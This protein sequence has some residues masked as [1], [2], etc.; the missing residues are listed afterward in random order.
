MQ[1]EGA[2]LIAACLS[3]CHAPF[4]SYFT[5][6]GGKPVTRRG[7]PPKLVPVLK[8]PPAY[9][10]P[11]ASATA[12]VNQPSVP[13]FLPHAVEP[14]AHVV[15]VGS[16]HFLMSVGP[17]TAVVWCVVWSGVQYESRHHSCR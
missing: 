13:R 7:P 9:T 3:H 15:A 14:S 10:L 6:V 17:E 12:V 5:M 4:R 16:A 11:A 1:P 2:Q 8:E